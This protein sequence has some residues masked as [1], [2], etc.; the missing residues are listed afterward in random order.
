MVD[1]KNQK[2]GPYIASR[3][4]SVRFVLA[5]IRLPNLYANENGNYFVDR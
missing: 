5:V 3:W 1:N 4:V 2:D